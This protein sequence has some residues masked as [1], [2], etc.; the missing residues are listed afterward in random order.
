LPRRRSDDP[1]KLFSTRNVNAYVGS[2]LGEGA[3]AATYHLFTVIHYIDDAIVI[4]ISA[5]VLGVAIQRHSR[6]PV[7]A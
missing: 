2:V 3:M 4:F 1:F 6:D 7:V 5:S